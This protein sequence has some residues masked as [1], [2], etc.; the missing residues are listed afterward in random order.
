MNETNEMRWKQRLENFGTA[1][2]QLTKACAQDQFSDLE[3]A[4]MIKTFEFC[5]ELSWNT[6]KDLL[7]YEGYTAKSPRA[8]IR[9]SFESEYLDESDCETL[10]DALGKRNL[11]AHVYREKLALEVETLIKRHCHPAL[12]RLHAS[13]SAK[14]AS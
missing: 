2:S 6:L 9:K 14:A 4:G 8:V 10:L 5:F 12:L 1:L 7:V 13:L 11:L 3:R